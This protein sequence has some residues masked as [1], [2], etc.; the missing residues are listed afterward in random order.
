MSFV[1]NIWKI[2]TNYVQ[3]KNSCYSNS[4]TCFRR[5]CVQAIYLTFTK[6][7]N[8]PAATINIHIHIHSTL[9][10]HGFNYYLTVFVNLF[11]GK[12]YEPEFVET[13]NQL[14]M[15]S[16]AKLGP[17][18]RAAARSEPKNVLIPSCSL[19][20]TARWKSGLEGPALPVEAPWFPWFP[21]HSHRRSAHYLSRLSSI[22]NSI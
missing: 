22:S 11:H 17:G 5:T 1:E 16:G 9:N 18:W 4:C 12:V 19:L 21:P 15:F 2:I 20:T 3:R 8:V 10:I 13:L 6:L 7:V 14:T